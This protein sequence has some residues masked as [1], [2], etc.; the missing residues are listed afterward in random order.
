[1]DVYFG[2]YD[3]LLQGVTPD[4]LGQAFLYIP[5]SWINMDIAIRTFALDGS[6]KR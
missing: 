1:L 5:G 3:L 2:V 4:Q 6:Q